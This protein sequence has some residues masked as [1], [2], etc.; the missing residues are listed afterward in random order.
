MIKLPL[1]VLTASPAAGNITAYTIELERGTLHLY[2]P[3]KRL[4]FVAE[5]LSLARSNRV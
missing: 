2:Y 1:T 4:S 5:F 3:V